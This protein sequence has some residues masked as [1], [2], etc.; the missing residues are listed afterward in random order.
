MPPRGT[1]ARQAGL[2]GVSDLLAAASE[3]SF[4]LVCEDP[5]GNGKENAGPSQ[6]AKAAKAGGRRRARRVDD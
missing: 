3:S 5:T 6:S 1:F 4:K 2:E